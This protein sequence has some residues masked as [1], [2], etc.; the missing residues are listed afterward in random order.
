MTTPA[1][2]PPP[3]QIGE[4]PWWIRDYAVWWFYGVIFCVTI[5]PEL[6][7]KKFDDVVLILV[8]IPIVALL[9]YGIG[10]LVDKWIL[11]EVPEPRDKKPLPI[12]SPIC[13]KC[14]YD[15]RASL[16][17]CPECGAETSF[18][19][20]L[21]K[22]HPLERAMFRRSLQQHPHRPSNDLPNSK[23]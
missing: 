15:V 23:G 18:K 7:N 13:P 10:R 8:E 21:D 20:W 19:L 4:W 6:W 11:G 14:G 16:E 17:R 9:I 1:K 22:Q 5:I 3:L 12:C 2:K